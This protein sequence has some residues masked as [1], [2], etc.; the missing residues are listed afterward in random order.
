MKKNYSF[1]LIM[2]ACI[3]CQNITSSNY[4]DGDDKVLK[5]DVSYSPE[6]SQSEIKSISGYASL[7]HFSDAYNQEVLLY[8]GPSTNLVFAVNKYRNPIFA[9]FLSEEN[10]YIF[11]Y[12]ETALTLV[13]AVSLHFIN[14]EDSKIISE[15]KQSSNFNTLVDR[16]KYLSGQDRTFIHDELTFSLLNEISVQLSKEFSAKKDTQSLNFKHEISSS[17]QFTLTS[18]TKLPFSINFENSVTKVN[19]YIL[20]TGNPL[21]IENQDV[22]QTK[23]AFT[24]NNGGYELSIK[25]DQLVLDDRFQKLSRDFIL[26]SYLIFGLDKKNYRNN[27]IAET[28]VLNTNLPEN[29]TK[30]EAIN[31]I[32]NHFQD[33]LKL[34]SKHLYMQLPYNDLNRE[35]FNSFAY[36]VQ[37]L[38]I[39]QDAPS[40]FYLIVPILNLRLFVLKTQMKF[41]ACP[42]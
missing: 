40:P 22:P 42:V 11:G 13:S 4:N 19:S 3:G 15:L 20:L 14:S 38:I 7:S 35:H 6:I 23:P 2:L 8:E 21:N 25:S 36:F 32:R 1:F 29:P 41:H 28:S 5:F 17:N 24:T 37:T 27:N 16:L 34:F 12:K 9:S 39:S 30:L 33:E 31:H 10:T 26:K 18:N